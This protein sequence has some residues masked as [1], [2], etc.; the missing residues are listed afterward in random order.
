MAT[1]P[2]TLA[3]IKAQLDRYVPH[4]LIEDACREAGH[5]WRE[6]KLGPVVTVHLFLLQ[7]LARVALD[8]LRHVSGLA[9]SAQACCKAYQR[10][11]LEVLRR[12]VE[13][14]YEPVKTK[15]SRW[16]G[17]RIRLVD[18]MSFI[19]ADTPALGKKYGKASNHKG[20]S[21]GY[22]MPKLLAS[23]DLF[24]GMIRRVIALPGTRGERSCPRSA[25]WAHEARRSDA[26]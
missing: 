10:L 5:T 24:S 26:R 1:I 17:L 11:P 4:T 3:G 2:H 18:G 13:A 16:H 20:V 7:L 14:V 12:L 19:T 22:P 15:S 25:A 6:R 9:V 8:G 21:K 23:I